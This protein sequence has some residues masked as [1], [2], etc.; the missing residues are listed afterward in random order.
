MRHR[1]LALVVDFLD[2]R[3]KRRYR[4]SSRAAPRASPRPAGPPHC[5][6]ALDAGRRLPPERFFRRRLRSAYPGK[7]TNLERFFRALGEIEFVLQN[8]VLVLYLSS[9]PDLGLPLKP[10][11]SASFGGVIGRARSQGFE[12]S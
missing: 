4:A 9:Y 3:F 5:V 6:S 2:L 10:F 8:A 7:Q 1:D 12:W 11:R